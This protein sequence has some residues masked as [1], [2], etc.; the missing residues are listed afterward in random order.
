MTWCGNMQKASRLVL[1]SNGELWMLIFTLYGLHPAT[2]RDYFWGPS[3]KVLLVALVTLMNYG[4][5]Q[6]KH[7]WYYPIPRYVLLGVYE[8]LISSN[9]VSLSLPF[10]LY[11]SLQIALC[12]SLPHCLSPSSPLGRLSGIC[13]AHQWGE[14]KANWE[15]LL[16]VNPERVENLQ[17][18]HVHCSPVSPAATSP[19]PSPQYT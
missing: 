14:E 15:P 19:P 4:P 17:R 3:P 13:Q 6:L 11:P 2:C 9:W 5:A 1:S 16:A 18:P 7:V 10:F 8:S 12:A